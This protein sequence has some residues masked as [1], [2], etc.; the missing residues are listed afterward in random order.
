MKRAH[1]FNVR[2]SD[3]EL[4]ALRRMAEAMGVDCATW[5][6]LQIRDHARDAKKGQG[7]T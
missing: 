5:L 6:R 3:E 1:Q 2:L 7:G 4:E